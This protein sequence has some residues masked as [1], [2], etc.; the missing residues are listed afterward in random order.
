MIKLQMTQAEF[1]NG[2]WSWSGAFGGC[3]LALGTANTTG[4]LAYATLVGGPG[5]GALAAGLTCI[6][7][8]IMGGNAH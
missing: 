5:G 3:G 4:A 2:G 8:G 6:V 7:G 1:V